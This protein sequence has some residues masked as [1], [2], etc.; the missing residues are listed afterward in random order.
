MVLVVF[1]KNYFQTHLLYNYSIA[2]L[3][4]FVN[5]KIHIFFKKIS[6][7]I[8]EIGFILKHKSIFHKNHRIFDGKQTI[9]E[10]IRKSKKVIEI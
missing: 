5:P 6:I 1:L 10:K 7:I 4:A 9:L 2:H 3:F 8:Y